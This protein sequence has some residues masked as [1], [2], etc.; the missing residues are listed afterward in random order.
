MYSQWDEE[1]VL[2]DIFGK[3][4]KGYFV[5]IG[6]NDGKTVSNT[7]ALVERGWGGLMIEPDPIA[8]SKLQSL[9]GYN[10]N[11]TLLNCAVNRHRNGYIIEQF[12]S[13][14]RPEAS[15]YSTTEPQNMVKWEHES[16]FYPSHY[17]VSIGFMDA[18]KLAKSRIDFISIDTEGT[19]YD[20]FNGF[21][22]YLYGRGGPLC[23]CVEHDEKREE[24]RLSARRAGYVQIAENRE[25]LMFVRQK[26]IDMTPQV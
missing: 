23:F 21:M 3:D 9:H 15:V 6:A 18:L 12:W 4:Y 22:E 2:I 10:K 1:Q 20:I 16:T 26:Y 14:S 17:V 13:A 5:D 25:N 8:F 11:I 7:L 19:S 24:C